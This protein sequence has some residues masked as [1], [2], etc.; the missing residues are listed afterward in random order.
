[1]ARHLNYSKHR[2]RTVIVQVALLCLLTLHTLG[3]FHKHGTTAEQDACVACQVVNHQAALDLPDV[4]S[5]LLL[6]ALVFLF[7]VIH[8]HRGV[9]PGATLFTRPRS[10][11]PP[12]SFI[13]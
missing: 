3:L 2:W 12:T 13:S 11:A 5:G 4:G 8:W 7:L 10:R 6:P 1:M 9:V